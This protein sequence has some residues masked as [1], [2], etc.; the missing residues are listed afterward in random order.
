MDL[1]NTM[2]RLRRREN[3]VIFPYMVVARP[4]SRRLRRHVVLSKSI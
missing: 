2:Q 1:E 3:G 4:F